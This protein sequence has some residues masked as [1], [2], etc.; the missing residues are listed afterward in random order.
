MKT[1]RK[2]ISIKLTLTMIVL[3]FQISSNDGFANG[4]S[5]FTFDPIDENNIQ[6]TEQ[7]A[8]DYYNKKLF[9]NALVLFSLI[10]DSK[11]KDA[12]LNYRIGV[13]YLNTLHKSKAIPYLE[14][15]SGLSGGKVDFIDLNFYLARAYHYNHEFD[16]AIGHYKSYI[17]ILDPKKNEEAG[18]IAEIKRYIEMCT[19]G[20]ALLRNPV[21]VKI[22][23]LNGNIN[24]SFSDFLP[25]AGSD[26]NS[27]L[28]ASRKH[29]TTGGKYD[30]LTQEYYEDIYISNKKGG[31]WEPAK[32]IGKNVNN[33]F[34]EVPLSISQDGKKLFLYKSDQ[35]NDCDIYYSN[36]RDH[37]WSAPVSM[38]HHV[39]SGDME[40]GGSISP[41]GQRFYF[42]SDREGGFGEMDIYYSQL[43]ADGN[44]GPA[45]NLGA[46][47]NTKYNEESPFAFSDGK[48]LYFSSEGHNSMGGFD[49]F[50]STF[51]TLNQRWSTPENLGFPI[52]SADDEMSIS[53]SS[54]GKQAYYSANKED[55]FG[56]EDIYLITSDELISGPA[57]IPSDSKTDDS[58][59][60]NIQMDLA[61]LS[62]ENTAFP[63]AGNI[64][65]EKVHFAYNAFNSITEYSK[66]NINAVIKMLNKFPEMKIQLNGYSDN[67]GNKEYNQALSEKRAKTVYDYI[68][69]NGI[70]KTRLA[71]K[72]CGNTSLHADHHSHGL[73]DR[74]VEFMI[75]NNTIANQ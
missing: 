66:N 52:N 22:E 8:N 72:G 44:W 11:S 12:I 56:D 9:K 51:N 69:S 20:K 71:I 75:I 34:H 33:I 14:K 59:S 27:I 36:L 6:K 28:F 41:D 5:S 62:N 74:K 24:S 54:N 37:E 31:N 19:N 7:Q 13:C 60:E 64:L 48:T 46:G 1:L 38:G 10:Y 63:Q 45:V 29:V 23:H 26:G 42:S 32:P 30:P 58:E 73:K 43:Q 57:P 2:E 4:N 55:S 35:S 18:E 53:F 68:I 65:N 49:L 15:V 17:N 16:K 61:S 3:V 21:A 40:T 50:T 67:K 25:L 39:N 47:I 70:D